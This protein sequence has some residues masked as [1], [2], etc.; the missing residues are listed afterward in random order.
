M[1]KP[2]RWSN[3]I[4]SITFV[5]LLVI[6]VP[7]FAMADDYMGLPNHVKLDLSTTCPVCGMRVG[8]E[9]AGGVTYAYRDG[10][11]VGFAGAAAMVF[12]DG[13]TV[14]FEG[15]RCLFIYNTFPKRFGVSPADITNRYVTDFKSGKMIEAKDAILV[16]GSEVKGPM[17]Y[18]LIPFSEKQEAEK[19]MAEHQGK[20]LVGLETVVPSDVER[21]SSR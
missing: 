14:G 8:G 12:K 11:L 9:L 13:R 2:I 17:G 7:L 18:D 15:A 21:K 6:A 3:Q 16:L 4:R 19:F 20:R 5:S 1:K 10:R